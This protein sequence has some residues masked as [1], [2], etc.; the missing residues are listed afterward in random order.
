[1]EVLGRM[2]ARERA[3]QKV[4]PRV[5]DGDGQGFGKERCKGVGSLAKRGGL[6]TCERFGSWGFLGGT[7]ASNSGRGEG[8]QCPCEGGVSRVR[9][10]G[11]KNKRGKCYKRM[12]VRV[13]G[14]A[15]SL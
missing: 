15:H 4:H 3:C 2:R 6:S 7:G 13:S 5:D 8:R 1:M 12:E 14:E 11:C 9:V 10:R